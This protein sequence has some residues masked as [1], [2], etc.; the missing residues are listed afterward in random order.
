MQDCIF[1]KIIRKEAPGFIIDENEEVIVFLSY[2]NHPLIVTKKHIPNIYEMDEL[3]GAAV[4]K[5][6]IKISRAVKIGLKCDGVNLVQANDPAGQQDVFHFHLHVKPRWKGDK[7]VLSWDSTKN[8]P[9][10]LE[11]TKN[12]II[13]ALS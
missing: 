10:V 8:P 9:K 4:M 6:A 3:T 11:E 7:V 1:C 12:K 2:E 13:K 5:E